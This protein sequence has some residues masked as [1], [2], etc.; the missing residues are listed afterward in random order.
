MNRYFYLASGA[1]AAGALALSQA[2]CGNSNGGQ[3][4]GLSGHGPAFGHGL[5][6]AAWSYSGDTGP[7]K[8]AQL[9]PAYSACGEGTRQSP[10]D[11]K[12]KIYTAASTLEF[13]YLPSTGSVTNNGHTFV[14]S[15]SGSNYITVEK[16][17][18]DLVEVKFHA[19][20]EHMINGASYPLEAQM[21]HR[22][23]DGALAIVTQLFA[24]GAANPVIAGIWPA[25]GGPEGSVAQ[26]NQKLDPWELLFW[27]KSHFSYEGSLSEPPCSELV[28]WYVLMGVMTA[29]DE[30]IAKL[31]DTFGANARPVQP[32][33]NRFPHFSRV[34]S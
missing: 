27:D 15:P 20:A 18:Y 11:L 19:P 8:W 22:A 21:V 29:S 2:S 14:Y 24:S 23:E 1:L 25:A 10:V 30:Q 5:A 31:K 28:K 3:P 4:M 9:D 17:R 32:L 7:A 33:N 13:S 6:T 26:V 34:K 16:K 12:G